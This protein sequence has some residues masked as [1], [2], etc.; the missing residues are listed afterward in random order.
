MR[1]PKK[2]QIADISIFEIAK[3]I[4][5]SEHHELPRSCMASC[6]LELIRHVPLKDE[7]FK[8]RT[9]I[10]AYKIERGF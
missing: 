9:V 4:R 10:R 7:L 3:A 1:D 8:I 2:M 5:G 6:S